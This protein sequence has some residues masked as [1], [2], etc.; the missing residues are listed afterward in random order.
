[1]VKTIRIKKVYFDLILSGQKRLEYRS[2]K[3]YYRFFESKDLRA[4]VLHYQG[5][6]RLLVSVVSV[7]KI[8]RPKFLEKSGIDFTSR[9]YRIELKNPILF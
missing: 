9:V 1:M 4:L 6:R 2:V 3:P 8:R 5:K 7:D